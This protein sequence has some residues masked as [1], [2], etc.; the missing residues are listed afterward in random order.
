MG[1]VRDF[2]LKCHGLVFRV[3]SLDLGF[4][5]E[6]ECHGLVFRVESLGFSALTA[7]ELKAKKSK[8]GGFSV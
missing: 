5:G 8:D 2:M 6:A 7:K 3:E 1:V 4:R